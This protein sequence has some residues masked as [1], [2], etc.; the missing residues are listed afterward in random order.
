[1]A[2]WVAHL[3][4]PGEAEERH[5]R[6]DTTVRKEEEMHEVEHHEQHEHDDSSKL[7]PHYYTKD[8]WKE[9]MITFKDQNRQAMDLLKKIIAC[10]NNEEGCNE[11]D[12]HAGKQ[13]VE[14]KDMEGD[15]NT[16]GDN[17]GNQDR[18][19]EK[20]VQEDETNEHNTMQDDKTESAYEA[21]GAIIELATRLTKNCE[22]AQD[23]AQLLHAS[24]PDHG[25]DCT[26]ENFEHSLEK[27]TETWANTMANE[28]DP[29]KAEEAAREIH[30]GLNKAGISGEG[31][32][33]LRE[34]EM[35]LLNVDMLPEQPALLAMPAP[36]VLLPPWPSPLGQ[37]RRRHHVRP[38]SYT[39]QGSR[40]VTSR[41]CQLAQGF[42]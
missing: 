5:D 7:M 32:E 1:L 6:D 29:L 10:T 17:Q 26:N 15:N 34:A 8:K 36:L 37:L 33:A 2:N 19:V 42:L 3:L 25:F 18:L 40:M 24:D 35:K 41:R 23:I 13:A 12:H 31:L 22:H 4:K 20:Q 30:N 28:D 14:H 21:G 27:Y 39:R 11:G 16:T 38:V 9:E